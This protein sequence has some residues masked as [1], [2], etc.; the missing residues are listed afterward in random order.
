MNYKMVLSIL[1]KVLLIEGLL[2]FF[3]LLIGI[4]YG[5]GNFLSFLLPMALLFALGIPLSC[6]KK[7]YNS[8]YAK[9]GFVVVASSW[10]I[11]SVIGALPFVISGDIPYYIDAFFETVS[12]F[13]TT[14]ASILS[15]VEAMSKQC[16]F[17]VPLRILSVVWVFLFLC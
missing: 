10:I 13:T 5:E 4:Y 17:G 11:M 3:P 9:E 6:L 8:M 15:N 14:G 16:C 1:G 7:Q 12:G 2:M